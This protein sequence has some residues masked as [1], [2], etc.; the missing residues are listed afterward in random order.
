[1]S[2]P[3]QPSQPPPLSLLRLREA[4]I[5]RLCGLSAAALGMDLL[6]RR[7]LT[8]PR[9]EGA[10]LSA[11]SAAAAG[12]ADDAPIEAWAELTGEAPTMGLR[13]GCVRHAAA[14]EE[15][16]AGCEHIAA[17]LTAWVRAP[18]D[19]VTPLTDA[20]ELVPARTLP[21]NA[22]PDAAKLA[23][24]DPH[25]PHDLRERT[26]AQPTQPHLLIA[27]R[28]RRSQTPW[29][30]D[31]ELRRL[32][33]GDVCAIARRALGAEMDEAEARATLAVALRDRALL[34]ALMGR[35]D[36][37]AAETLAWLR[38]A[39]GALTSADVDA[40]AARAGRPVSGLRAA[41]TT[42]ERHGLVF[43]ALLGLAPNAS[44]ADRAT[45]AET[46][47]E[48][49]WRRLKGWRIA[50][51]TRD[52]LP[53]TLPIAAFARPTPE[54]ANHAG[55]AS[56]VR[57]DEPSATPPA[58]HVTMRA[59]RLRVEAGSA[60]TLLLA[61]A[62]LARAPAPL[63]PFA[64]AGRVGHGEASSG[65]S[66]RE[67]LARVERRGRAGGAGSALMPE[68]LPDAQAHELARGVGVDAA[69]LRLARR[70]LLWARDQE[71]APPVTDL[72]RTPTP[73]RPHAFRSGFRVWLSARSPAD[74][75]DLER[76]TK[77][78]RLR[79]DHTHEAFRPA[80]LAEEAA[81]ARAFVAHLLGQAQPGV[82]RRVADLLDLI[83]R[84]NPLFLRGRQMA[85][86]APA[87]RIER[88]SDGRPLRPTVRAEWDA[89]E[90]AYIQALLLGPLRWWGA[91]DL[92]SADDA[93]PACFRLTPLG[94]FLLG[95]ADGEAADQRADGAEGERRALAA[96]TFDWGPMATPTREGA[97]AV[98][99]LMASPALL[100]LLERWAQPPTL[101]GGRLIYSFGVEQACANFDLGLRPED[102][103][104]T[105]RALGLA[106]AAQTL[107]PRLEGWRA[108]Y[109]DARLRMGVTLVE[110]RDEATLREALAALPGLAE[111]ARWLSASQVALGQA[112]GATLRAAL[113][114]RG[115]EL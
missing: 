35:L 72:A 98:Q 33:A 60:R 16:R 64:Q 58:P 45:S 23:A 38:L 40:L 67:P 85:F 86:S 66:E 39:G 105:L 114:G 15:L 100:D 99:P 83:W 14:G 26:P 11:T 87:W 59:P 91:L 97:L 88:I 22:L 54:Q 111:R 104:A 84:V 101:A 115:W 27:P 74:L 21:L 51:E 61:L 89:A 42:L 96:L 53:H 3:S 4:D 79:Y 12:S 106:R 8:Q 69:I 108:G 76:L 43:A 81:A 55:H 109:G 73:A 18:A 20:I 10:R 50:P 13:W 46:G 113:A 68:D 57:G 63:G 29:T 30:L 90:G 62:L 107:A 82:W 95:R 48:P 70:T 94:Q 6:T 93:T 65:A 56:H 2:Q 34:R 28:Q 17:L 71:A 24:G 110:G 5:V 7:A 41:L 36:P 52:A 47:D 112:D 44:S 9:R 103:L 25:N 1:M 77:R 92:A 102:A 19:F 37:E 31:D 80:A 75:V 78:V 49:G 32:P